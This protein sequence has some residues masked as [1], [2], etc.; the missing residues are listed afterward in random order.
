MN[1]FNAYSALLLLWSILASSNLPTT[2]TA[3][4][5]PIEVITRDFAALTRKVTAHHILLPKS[6][7]VALAL[8]QRIRNKISPP[9]DSDVAPTY[10]VDAFA[11]AAKKFSRDGE[12]GTKGGLLGTL[13]PQGYC[14][15]VE[16]DEACFAVPL[17]EVCGPIESEY[18]Y[19]L[20]LVVER[21]NC[22]KLDGRYTK[23]IRG[24]DGVS[25]V[26]VGEDDAGYDGGAGA[27]GEMMKLAMQQVGF[28]I[29]VSFA[30]GIVAEV[31]AKA[32]NVVDTLP[33]E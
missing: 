9:K 14:R 17:G 10:I 15:A 20:L 18:G 16:L 30:G 33:W 11:A 21:T 25:K 2:A 22:P 5:N 31:A 27:G 12:T 26:F 13:A 19:H 28:W 3:F 24:R 29:G 4:I 8:K 1:N 6:D 7:D 32:A 23:I